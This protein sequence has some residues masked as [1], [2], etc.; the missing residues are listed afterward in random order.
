LT[1]PSC[2][3]PYLGPDIVYVPIADL[4]PMRS[5]LVWRRPARD[6]KLT[7]LIRIAR[8]VLR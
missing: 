3:A 6:R 5:A 4:P 2:A 8:E 1:C 7:E